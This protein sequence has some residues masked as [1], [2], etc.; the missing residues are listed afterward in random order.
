MR[1]LT[2]ERALI[3]RITHIRNVPWILRHGLHCPNGPVLDPGF[4]PIGAAD[5]IGK[6]ARRRVPIPP[7]GSFQDYIPFYFTP[8]SPMLLNVQTGYGVPQVEG[9]DIVILMSSVHVL[10]EQGI[11]YVFTDCHAFMQAAQWSSE[12]QDLDRIDWPLLR[13]SDFAWDPDDPGKKDR[14]QAE[15]LVHR[16]LPLAAIRGIG[17]GD[18]SAKQRLEEMM[19]QAGVRVPVSA[20]PTWYCR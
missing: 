6:R 2:R 8:R 18:A 10:Q 14:Y 7:H 3:F 5:L 12:L 19:G 1:Q 9:T 11:A 13:S 15:V 20:E 16:H 4:V 17:C